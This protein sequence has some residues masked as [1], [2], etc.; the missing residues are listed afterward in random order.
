[1]FDQQDEAEAAWVGLGAVGMRRYLPF[2][3]ESCL[4]S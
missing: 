1:M 4:Q 2:Q 3:I